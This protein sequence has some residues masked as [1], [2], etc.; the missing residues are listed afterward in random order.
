MKVPALLLFISIYSC[1]ASRQLQPSISDMAKA[2]EKV[3]G[4]T[5]TEMQEGYK[6]YLSKCSACH[7]LHDP[8]EFTSQKWEPILIKMYVKA[9]I[10]QEKQKLLIHNYVIAKSK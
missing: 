9:K 1:T 3:P 2:A 10:S 8:A 7:R 5:Y 6:L 4:I